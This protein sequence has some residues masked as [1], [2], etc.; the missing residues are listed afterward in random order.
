MGF[1]SPAKAVLFMGVYSHFFLRI[2]CGYFELDPGQEL[3]RQ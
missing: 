3:L 1:N 2:M